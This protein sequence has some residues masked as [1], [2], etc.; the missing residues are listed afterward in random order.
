MRLRTVRQELEARL[1]PVSSSSFK[2]AKAK[3]EWTTFGD[4]SME[5]RVNLFHVELPDR[6]IVQILVDG[7]AVGEMNVA[8]KTAR[9]QR[10]SEKGESV[11]EVKEGQVIQIAYQGTVL[12]EGS[13]YPD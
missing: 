12:L 11:V 3:A 13:F 4:G 5:C 7:K 1:K 10:E 8:A 6:S 9:F 2:G